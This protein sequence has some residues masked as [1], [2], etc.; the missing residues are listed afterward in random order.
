MVR[1][2]T[3]ITTNQQIRRLSVLLI[4]DR[5]ILICYVNLSEPLKKFLL[6]IQGKKEQKLNL[7]IAWKRDPVELSGFHV[8]FSTHRMTYTP[9]LVRHVFRHSVK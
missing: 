9:K 3:R 1:V 4:F 5:Y 7:E 8:F 6:S 2:V